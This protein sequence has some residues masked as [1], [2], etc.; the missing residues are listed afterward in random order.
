MTVRPLGVS[1]WNSGSTSL[2][3]KAG[4]GKEGAV[5]W[6]VPKEADASVKL[7]EMGNFWKKEGSNSKL[8][9]T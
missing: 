6:W 3:L 1:S 4:G 8:G 9:V 5:R 7:G 2:A